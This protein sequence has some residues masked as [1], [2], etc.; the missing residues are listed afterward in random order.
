M[1]PELALPVVLGV[2]VA[3]MIAAGAYVARGRS[4]RDLL[5]WFVAA[6]AGFWGAHLVAALFRLPILTVGDLQIAA[7]IAGGAAA[8][9]LQILA[10][11]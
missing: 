3:T 6:Q 9:V 11:R 8:I 1:T 4:R 5:I 7:G 10:S 2:L